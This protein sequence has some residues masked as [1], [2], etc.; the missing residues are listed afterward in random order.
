MTSVGI[1]I[2][3]PF[4]IAR[5]AFCAFNVRGYREGEAVA[6]IEALRKEI[7]LHA[8]SGFARGVATSLY[9]GGGTPSL[10]DPDIIC[11][12]I[13]DCHE[14][15]HLSDDAEVTLEVH[16]ATVDPIRLR[17]LRRGGVTRLSIGVQSFS[18]T[19]LVRLGRHHTAKDAISAFYNARSAGFNSIGM[20]LM[21]ALPEP[22]TWA[23]TL[24]RAIALSPEHISIYGLSIEAGTQ[25]Y[26]TRAQMKLPSEAET[27]AQY[28]L[29]GR[30]LTRNGYEQYEI[31]NFAKP[32]FACRH[33][34]RYWDRGS[35][36]GIGLSAASYFN[37]THFE[38]TDTIAT[39]TEKIASGCLPIVKR[40]PISE[41]EEW[42]DRVIFGLRKTAGIPRDLVE[43]HPHLKTVADRF[44][45]DGLLVCDLD[46][47]RLT[48]KGRLL[49][50]EVAVAFL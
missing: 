29:A 28:R 8:K 19:Q 17:A 34:L 21:Y 44:I 7:V 48:E 12:L 45:E 26:K 14:H 16:P 15:L 36:L 39:Y 25:F 42:T 9:I 41:E 1:Y 49:S 50:D 20:D 43:P 13:A 38:N 27:V 18:D 35:V 24:N 22:D 31:S 47:I 10:Y 46:R 30:R 37:R 6:Y 3:V 33:N 4:C 32:G 40:H 23:D 5:C 11:R 2:D